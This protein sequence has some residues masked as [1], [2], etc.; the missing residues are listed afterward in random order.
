MGTSIR[1]SSSSTPSQER[2]QQPGAARDLDVL[3]G[4]PLE[5][6]TCSATSPRTRL[7]GP[8]DLVVEDQDAA[9]AFSTDLFGWDYEA[10]PT[11]QGA[12]GAAPGRA[13]PAT[14]RG[15]ATDSMIS[16]AAA[17]QPS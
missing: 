9:K 3:A 15:P 5:L 1:L 14:G 6:P 8:L 13:R 7:E 16:E 2:S 11:G 17:T 12:V 10:F 4:P